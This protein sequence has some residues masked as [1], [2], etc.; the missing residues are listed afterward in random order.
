[1]G[2][3]LHINNPCAGS[4]SLFSTLIIPVQGREVYTPHY[5]SLCGVVEFILHIIIPCAVS[6]GGFILHINNP[7][8]GLWSLYS[9]L[10]F[11]VRCCEVYT[12]HYYSLCGVVGFILHINNHCAG[13]LRGMLSKM[14][15]C[16]S[17][18]KLCGVEGSLICLEM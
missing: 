6:G 5:Q 7:C 10:L 15:K 14:A 12:P 9:T 4:W 2:F 3:I 1:M 13:S 18:K 17:R 16:Q 8:A 11:P